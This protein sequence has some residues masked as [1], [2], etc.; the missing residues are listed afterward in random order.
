MFWGNEGLIYEGYHD[1]T[2]NGSRTCLEIYILSDPLLNL[3][4][5]LSHSGINKL[6]SEFF[7][8]IFNF[9][10]KPELTFSVYAFG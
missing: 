8:H 1:L 7:F 3:S 10:Q 6:N 5:R 2:S 9:K 4:S